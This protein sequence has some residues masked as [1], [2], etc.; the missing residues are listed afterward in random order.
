MVKLRHSGYKHCN[1]EGKGNKGEHRNTSRKF[2]N[3]K[4]ERNRSWRRIKYSLFT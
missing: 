3:E 4:A 2:G 1:S